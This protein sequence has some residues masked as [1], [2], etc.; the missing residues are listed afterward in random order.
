MSNSELEERP[1]PER[2][3]SRAGMPV[4]MSGTG[5]VNE[6]GFTPAGN[7]AAEEAEAGFGRR[8]KED[9]MLRSLLVRSMML[10]WSLLRVYSNVNDQDAEVS[11]SWTGPA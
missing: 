7:G 5:E 1:P 4:D 9:M 8:L 11:G 10:M 3:S 2:R 6:E